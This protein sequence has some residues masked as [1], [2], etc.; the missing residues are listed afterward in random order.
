MRDPENACICCTHNLL[1]FAICG[2]C[3]I[4]LV[5]RSVLVSNDA[6]FLCTHYL[7]DAVLHSLSTCTFILF[8]V[9]SSTRSTP[10]R[11]EKRFAFH[12]F[13][14]LWMSDL[15]QLTNCRQCRHSTY[16]FCCMNWAANMY[17][18][19]Q[20]C[21]ALTQQTQEEERNWDVPN[22]AKH[23]CEFVHGTQYIFWDLFDCEAVTS[24]EYDQ[25]Y[26]WKC[27]SVQCI[28]ET[29]TRTTAII[30]T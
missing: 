23:T 11:W 17:I 15:L 28:D 4:L 12:Y 25:I 20:L 1:L 24:D 3:C 7:F 13:R 14:W 5:Y 8:A 21:N 16:Y 19:Q 26:K 10:A 18:R 30:E 29:K 9:V 27:V 2:T 6:E 22:D